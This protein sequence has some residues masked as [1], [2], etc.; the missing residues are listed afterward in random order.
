MPNKKDIAKSFAV[1]NDYVGF[2][3]DREGNGFKAFSA[4][5]NADDGLI[6][7]YPTLYIGFINKRSQIC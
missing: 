5:K 3:F 1:K 2:T 4:N 6:I 7:G